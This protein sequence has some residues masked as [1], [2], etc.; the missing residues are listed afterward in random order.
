MSKKNEV[1]FIINSLKK[2]FI[3]CLSSFDIG[4]HAKNGVSV[5]SKSSHDTKFS[6]FRLRTKRFSKMAELFLLY[7]TR[8]LRLS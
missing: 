4:N 2:L 7:Y 5:H 3:R 6:I 1:V 8:K